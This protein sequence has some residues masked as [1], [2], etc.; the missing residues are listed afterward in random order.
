[1]NLLYLLSVFWSSLNN[2][3]HIYTMKGILFLFVTILFSA[4]TFAQT[5]WK[6]DP[7]HSSLNFNIA[8]S[9]IRIVNGKL[10]EYTGDLT[11]KGEAL[12]YAKF[13]FEVKVNSV[14]SN[15]DPRDNHLRSPDFF[16]V[17]KYPNMT[18]YTRS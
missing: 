6:V 4:G 18:W 7:Y 16:D 3:K 10:L 8:H 2:Q 17:E 15:V 14:N 13:N 9:G 5:Q 11:T 1:M 12:K